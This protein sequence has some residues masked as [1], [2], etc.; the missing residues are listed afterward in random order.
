MA[1][2][3]TANVRIVTRSDD[4]SHHQEHGANIPYPATITIVVAVGSRK[5][6]A[7]LKIGPGGLCV[8][9]A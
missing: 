5:H 4:G 7:T 3:K 8:E 2:K 9:T 6:Q 1:K